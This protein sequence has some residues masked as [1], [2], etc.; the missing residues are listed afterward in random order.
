MLARL[1][2]LIA[3]ELPT[4]RRWSGPDTWRGPLAD[5]VDDDLHVVAHL[6]YDAVDELRRLELTLDIDPR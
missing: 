6:L 1:A 5:Q 3:H 4:A 2:A